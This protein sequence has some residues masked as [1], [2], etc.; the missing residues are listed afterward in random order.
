MHYYSLMLVIPRLFLVARC[1]SWE[2]VEPLY[3]RKYG[4]AIGS[5]EQVDKYAFRRQ[6]E[7]LTVTVDC[8]NRNAS[9]DWHEY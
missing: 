3:T 4:A 9:Y 7:G 8:A 6:Y 5:L 2:E 1:C